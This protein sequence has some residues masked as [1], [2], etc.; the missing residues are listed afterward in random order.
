MSSWPIF[1]NIVFTGFLLQKYA[2][3]SSIANTLCQRVIGVAVFIVGTCPKLPNSSLSC[4]S[5]FSNWSD[6]VSRFCKSWIYMTD[7]TQQ[8]WLLAVLDL[9][10][11]RVVPR[12][13][14][15]PSIAFWYLIPDRSAP[16]FIL[17]AAAAAW[18][19]V[20]RRGAH[21]YSWYTRSI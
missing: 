14:H 21:V 15:T 7:R 6:T 11:G 12:S 4:S 18:A 20:S 10:T 17:S 1:V 9:M 5:S 13:L 16:I 3:L 19:W 8:M 2:R